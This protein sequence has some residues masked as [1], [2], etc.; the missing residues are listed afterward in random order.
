MAREK[1]LEAGSRGSSDFP[2]DAVF[3]L[4]HVVEELPEPV[5][6][7]GMDRDQAARREGGREA[8]KVGYRGVTG[9]VDRL[10]GYVVV[11]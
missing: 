5:G 2:P 9:C 3:L 7:E 11:P 10:Q 6:L 4:D 8:S 1:G